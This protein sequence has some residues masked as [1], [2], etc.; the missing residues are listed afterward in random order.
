M[1]NEIT[2]QILTLSKTQKTA[3]ELETFLKQ[4]LA[5]DK[6]NS[7]LLMRLAI[8]YSQMPFVDYALSLFYLK[9]ALQLDATNY[10]ALL[11]YAYFS[12][13]EFSHFNK[14]LI[15]QL[16]SIDPKLTQYNSLAYYLLSWIF[17]DQNNLDK[18]EFFLKKSIEI[19]QKHV[20]NYISLAQL[21]IQ[22]N[23]SG[24]AYTLFKQAHNNIIKIYTPELL[25]SEYDRTDAV[26]YINTNISGIY[27]TEPN[28]KSLDEA[29]IKYK[30]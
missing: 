15:H 19:Y 18:T 23:K 21:Y 16:T 22:Q 6:T 4:L 24:K 5:Q 14:E 13:F 2:I 25:T 12:Y 30:T 27:I 29:L 11:L 8:M 26:E 28:L 10:Q 3:L 20:S 1:K 17:L 9:K 7:E